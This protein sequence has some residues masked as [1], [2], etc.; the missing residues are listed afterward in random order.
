MPKRS[1][2]GCAQWWPVRIATP[3]AIEDRADVVRMHAV[4]ARTTG[5]SPCRG[6]VPMSR[7]PGIARSTRACR[8]RAGRRSCAAIALETDGLDVVERRA[9]ADRAGDVRRAR[10]ELVRQRRSRCVFSNVTERDHVAAAL[11]GGIAS[12]SAALP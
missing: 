6:A 12:S 11:N 4:H 1:I 9:Q 5:C 3:F 7:T 10:L 2:T 8:T